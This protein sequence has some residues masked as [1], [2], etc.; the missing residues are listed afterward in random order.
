M[1]ILA[2]LLTHPFLSTVLT[3]GVGVQAR[4]RAMIGLT[5]TAIDNPEAPNYLSVSKNCAFP[6]AISVPAMPVQ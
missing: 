4:K 5:T 2:E 3:V 1:P 6:P